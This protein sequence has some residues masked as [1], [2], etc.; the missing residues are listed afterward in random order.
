MPL[1]APRIVST[2][3]DTVEF[4]LE[5]ARATIR[6]WRP[7]EAELLFDI[8]RRPDVAQWLGD[9]RPWTGVEQ[10]R[11]NIVAWRD[12]ATDAVPST[13]AIV[14]NGTGVPVGSVSLNI[15]PQPGSGDVPVTDADWLREY[16]PVGGITNGVD[17]EVEVGWY[18]HPDAL[19]HGW[20]SEAA[21]AMLDHGF[22]HGLSRIWAVMWA[23]NGPS[24]AVCRRIG[25]T[26][27]GVQVDPWYGSS[28]D[29]TS[30]FFLATSP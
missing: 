25:M 4:G 9:P 24:A 8:R 20:A 29:A 23:S 22:K 26:E 6:H 14:P 2:A 16:T 27:L 30:R 13:C 17:G 15:M 28:D 10:A 21:A 3:M 12:R 18:L 11:A 7:D 19:G 5:T 1:T